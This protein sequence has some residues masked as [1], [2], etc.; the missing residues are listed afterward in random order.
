MVLR[1]RM[2]IICSL[3]VNFIITLYKE[4]FEDTTGVIRIRTRTSKMDLQNNDE[5][6]F[7]YFKRN[8]IANYVIWYR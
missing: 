1:L 7:K 3:N 8:F 6:C 4:E 2:Y 5:I